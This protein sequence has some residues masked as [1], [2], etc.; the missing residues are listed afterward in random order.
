[1]NDGHIQEADCQGDRHA[2]GQEA[3]QHRARAAALHQQEVRAEQFRVQCREERQAE[4][5]RVHC[6]SADV[7]NPFPGDQGEVPPHRE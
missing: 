1:M 2:A 6:R 5:R 3:R 4:E 7:T